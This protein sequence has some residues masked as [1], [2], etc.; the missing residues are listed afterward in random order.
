MSDDILNI[1]GEGGLLAK[2]LPGYEY[3]NSQ[4]SMAVFIKQAIAEQI[5]AFI[6]AGT[7]IGKTFGYLVPVMLSGK[8]TVVST[9]TKNL[10][11]QI[12][13]KDIQILFKAGVPEV[14]V[15]M[16]KG[17]QNYLCLYKFHQVFL[18]NSFFPDKN[19]LYSQLEEWINAT[20]FADREELHW[21]SDNTALWDAL[22]SGSESCLGSECPFSA[23]CF[24]AKLR[25]R[26]AKAQIIIVNHHLLSAELKM[27]KHGFGEIIPRFK[28]ILFDEAHSLEGIATSHLGERLSSNQIAELADDCNKTLSCLDQKDAEAMSRAV[29]A[30]KANSVRFYDFFPTHNEHSEKNILDENL[31]ERLFIEIF[32]PIKKELEVLIG[33]SEKFI[34]ADPD[35]LNIMSR[36]KV[37]F[38]TISGFENIPAK[39]WLNWYEKKTRSVSI[40]SAPLNI[41]FQMK[42]L[43]YD[44]VESAIFTSATLSAAGDFSFIKERLGLGDAVEKVY[45]S[46]FDLKNNALIFV[47]QKMPEPSNPDFTSKLADAIC[48]ILTISHGRALVLFTSYRNLNFVYN[49]VNGEIPYKI[50][51]QGEAPKS[52]LLRNFKENI[53][54]VLFAT[55]SFWEGVDVPG[56]SLSCVILDKLPFDSPGEP[57]TAARIE[58]L[59]ADGKNPFMDYQIPSAILHLRQGFGRLI[60]TSSDRGIVAIMDSRIITAR[61]GSLF[62][63][64][65]GTVPLTR[66]LKDIGSFFYGKDEQHGDEH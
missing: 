1:L 18:Q 57:L 48:E 40:Y 65:L 37:I 61:Y 30:I 14:D 31:R 36:S 45:P 10:Q 33:E 15:I 47:P 46:H 19:N 11:E 64:S 24:I 66:S 12:F 54:S 17:R 38:E 41:A 16:M 3:R 25:L 7:G 2:N 55:S 39:E 63:D 60:R 8:K 5:S 13:H 52:I 21:L 43:L 51:I 49:R 59:R 23:D 58:M 44:K 35:F 50:F 53:N 56:S 27:R 4:I 22:S 32:E 34:S 42:E 29:S 62:I 6:E 9:G 20:E 28:V 26:A